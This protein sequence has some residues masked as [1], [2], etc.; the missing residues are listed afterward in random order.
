MKL[1]VKIFT[2]EIDMQHVKIDFCE[3][4]CIWRV[5]ENV[6]VQIKDWS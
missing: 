6:C 2:S 1:Y 3:V 5:K 4:H